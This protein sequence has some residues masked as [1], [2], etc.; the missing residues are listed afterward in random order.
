MSNALW[1]LAQWFAENPIGRIGGCLCMAVTL[2][3]LGPVVLRGLRK[4][5]PR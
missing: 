3:T 4:R 2:G 1:Q 5:P